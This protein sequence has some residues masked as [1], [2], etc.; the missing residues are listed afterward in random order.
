LKLNL[1]C[2]QRPIEGFV[3]VDL[4]AGPGVEVVCDLLKPPWPFEASSIT[5]LR[6]EH[7]VEHVPDLIGFMNEAYRVCARGAL[8]TI[9]HPHWSSHRAWMDPTHIRPLPFEAWAYY[10]RRWREREKLD[11]YPIT[12]NFQVLS[13]NASLNPPWDTKSPEE[14]QFAMD[15]YLNVASDTQVVLVAEES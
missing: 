1:A 12:A 3:G 13:A 9:V 2:G 6:C 7:F 11:H 8:F 15:H 5:G 14:Q 4:V 10:D